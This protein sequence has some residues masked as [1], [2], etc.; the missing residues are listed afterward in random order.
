MSKKEEKTYQI[1]NLSEKQIRVISDALEMYSRLGILQFDHLIDHMFNWG[2]SQDFS[3]A[4]L[5]N[6]QQIE[7]HCTQ[8]KALLVS[9]DVE[10]SK[11]GNHSNWS[12]GI[13]SPKTPVVSQIS[14]ELEKDIEQAT[15]KD[16]RG[17]LQLSDE[18]PSIVKEENPRENK[19]KRI[20][21]NLKNEEDG[22]S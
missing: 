13:G 15:S 21:E 4:Y 5:E 8:I 11:Y 9:K 1:K 6:R 17:R 20:L 7:Y 14:Y 3:D 19:V 12:L 18:T 16:P 10:M 22:K 2:K